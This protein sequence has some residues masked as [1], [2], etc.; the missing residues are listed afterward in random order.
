M[1]S[2]QPSGYQRPR[3]LIEPKRDLFRE[4]MRT[5]KTQRILVGLLMI[6]FLTAGCSSSKTRVK[7]GRVYVYSEP[8]GATIFIDGRQQKPKTNT[9]FNLKPGLYKIR[10]TRQSD[11]S[12]QL[13]EGNATVKIQPGQASRITLTLN[14]MSIVPAASSND[15]TRPKSPGQKAIIGY[16]EAIS[17]K[18]LRKAFEYLNY[19]GQRSQ[20]SYWRWSRTWRDVASIRILGMDMM[21]SD[22]TSAVETNTVELETFSATST[23]KPDSR[24]ERFQVKITTV[25]ALPGLGLS[26]IQSVS[27]TETVSTGI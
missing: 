23:R 14:R 7:L 1:R 8:S 27:E 3:R 9:Y 19:Q 21:I 4:D 26:K 6:I 15:R 5:A 2:E 20:G 25:D 24:Q 11:Q 18:D 22:T 13:E 12:D 16:Y 17:K 10:L